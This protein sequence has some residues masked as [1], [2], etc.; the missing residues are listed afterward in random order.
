MDSKLRTCVCCGEKYSFCPRC[1]QDADKPLYYFSFCSNNCH[2]IYEITSRFENGQITANEAKNKLDKLDLSKL[3]SYGESY[4]SSIDKI[5]TSVIEQNNEIEEKK[6]STESEN[7]I[8]DSDD[9]EEKSIKKPRSRK[10]KID[11]E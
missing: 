6:E 7:E 11:V 3:N 9:I 5:F 2:D 1:P 4:K 8:Q 10:A